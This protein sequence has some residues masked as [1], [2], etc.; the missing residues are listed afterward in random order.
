MLERF[1]QVR[2]NANSLMARTIVR[3]SLLLGPIV[4]APALALGLRGRVAAS[5]QSFLFAGV[6]TVGLVVGV[7]AVWFLAP[8]SFKAARAD[9]TRR[10]LDMPLLATIPVMLTPAEARAKRRLRLV[11]VTSVVCAALA[12]A[13]WWLTRR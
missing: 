9:D 10:V 11:S 5:Q 13:A 2:Y 7:L 1:D 12:A 3:V 4:L 6:L 8:P